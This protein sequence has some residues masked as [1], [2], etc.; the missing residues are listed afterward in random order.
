MFNQALNVS[1]LCLI[2]PS[3]TGE[4]MRGP[5]EIAVTLN[6]VVCIQPHKK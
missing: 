5:T 3:F 4:N 2:G 1:L 6:T